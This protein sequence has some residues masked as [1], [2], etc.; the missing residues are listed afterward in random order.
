MAPLVR[1]ICQPVYLIFPGWA[2][3]IGSCLAA[4]TRRGIVRPWRQSILMESHWSAW[5]NIMKWIEMHKSRW[6]TY[7][8]HI[9]YCTFSMRRKNLS[10]KKTWFH[11]P[12]LDL[13]EEFGCKGRATIMDLVHKGLAAWQH[14]L[15]M[16]SY[17]RFLVASMC[18]GWNHG[19]LSH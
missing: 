4:L 15:W 19:A 5:S 18:C 13:A 8:L 10:W 11:F 14:R 16:L 7:P 6:C 1:Y 9:S 3:W 12:V 2:L 17:C